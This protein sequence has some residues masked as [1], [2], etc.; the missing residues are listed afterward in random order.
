VYSTNGTS[1]PASRTGTWSAGPLWTYGPTGGGASGATIADLDNDGRLDTVFGG[2]DGYVYCLDDHGNLKWRTLVASG[3]SV[4]FTP[5]VADVDRSGKL[6][7]VVSTNAPSVVR[8]NNTGSVIWTYNSAS[9]LFTTPTLVDVNGDG[10]PEVVTG[11]VGNNGVEFALWASNGTT[12]WYHSL[13]SYRQGG[14]SMAD[15]NGDGIP[16]ILVGVVSGTVY[17]LRGTDGSIFWS[18]NAGTTQAGT[19]VV[20][21]FDRS[22]TRE[23]AFIEGSAVDILTATGFLANG[24]TISPP[25]LSLRSAYQFPM[26]SPALADLTGNG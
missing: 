21:D 12:A 9:V 25:N 13:P 22:G 19:P 16:E 26:T 5:Q 6:S 10:F 7:V 1:L 17:N 15:V 2:T 8:L 4:P 24:W 18:Y 14:Q 23:V 11:D 3:Q 20:A